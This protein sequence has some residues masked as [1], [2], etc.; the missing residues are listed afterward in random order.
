MRLTDWRYV[1]QLIHGC[2]NSTCK[3]SL[4]ATGLRNVSRKPVRNYTP[5][6]AR[7]VALTLASGPEPR[8]RLCPIY[9]PSERIDVQANPEGPRDPTA[10]MQKLSD[11]SIVK[12]FCNRS[13]TLAELKAANSLHREYPYG[14]DFYN[15]LQY[16]DNVVED[17]FSSFLLDSDSDF[18]DSKEMDE[19]AA[20]K[21]SDCVQWLR[22]TC[23][24]GK[25]IHTY[26]QWELLNELI[27]TGSICSTSLVNGLHGDCLVILDRLEHRPSF[28]FLH[29]ILFVVARRYVVRI[30]PQSAIVEVRLTDVILYS[31]RNN[32][33]LYRG[34]AAKII[35]SLDNMVPLDVIVW[36]KKAFLFYWK[37]E[38]VLADGTMASATM[39]LLDAMFRHYV[40]GLVD[41][42]Q[43]ESLFAMPVVP[44]RLDA[45]ELARSYMDLDSPRA[46]HILSV[47][48]LFNTSHCATYFRTMNHLKM[49]KA[50]SDAE[51]VS[52]LRSRVYQQTMD[53]EP[54][55]RL[56][57]L[58]QHY[59]LIN[60]RRGNALQDAFDQLWQRRRSELFLPLRVRLGE[61]DE[62]E[63]GHDLGGVQIE[64]FNL[65]CRELFSETARKCS[66]RLA[67]PKL[68]V[69]SLTAS[70]DVHH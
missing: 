43:C 63:V 20:G 52:V 14:Q 39:K 33:E 15:A 29:R 42:E 56:K 13:D 67:C 23:S 18:K 7:A 60:V 57:Y 19:A 59:L 17:I 6:S 49:R 36:L 70:R 2:G 44:A 48:F 28:R 47:N 27:S 26:R 66:A 55:G 53:M 61:T 35:G 41:R 50:H 21:L 45:S 1:G 22:N 51:K 8:S 64:F 40:Y 24:T 30:Q 10:F 11:T 9:R 4:C 65:V 68:L 32:T 54:E 69:T 62:L 38:T 5:R 12:R 25:D 3:Q 58:E 34:L 37:G 31:N 46:E 16:W